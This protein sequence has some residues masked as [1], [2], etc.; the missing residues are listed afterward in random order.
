MARRGCGG[1]YNENCGPD[2]MLGKAVDRATLAGS[3]VVVAAGNGGPN[4][5]TISSPGTARTAITVGSSV[6]D[7][8]TIS[9]LYVNNLFMNSIGGQRSRLTNGNLIAEVKNVSGDGTPEDFLNSGNFV[10]KIALVRRGTL[11]LY[12][13]VRNSY[14]AGAVGVIIY[15]NVAGEF[16]P[17]FTNLTE[18]P[19]IGITQQD[20]NNLLNMLASGQVSANI[21]IVKNN[22]FAYTIKDYSSRGPIVTTNEILIKPDVVV[23]G[24]LV[25]SARYDS[26]LSGYECL[27]DK[28][29]VYDGTSMA[30]PHVSGLVALLKQKNP[31]WNSEEIKMAIRSKAIDSA[32]NSITVEGYGK[33]DA[34]RAIQFNG[35]PSIAS[36]KTSGKI[37]GIIDV[38]GSAKGRQFK[39]YTLYYGEGYDPSSWVVLKQGSVPVDNGILYSDFSTLSLVGKS[40]TLR[41]IV[42]NTNGEESEDRSF[43][44]VTRPQSKIVNK[45]EF[46]EIIS[47]M[48]RMRLEKLSNEAW[49]LDS[50]VVNQEI[51]ISRERAVKLDSYWNPVSVRAL[52]SG[53]YRTFVEFDVGFDKVNS[54]W[55]FTI[56]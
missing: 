13:K 7:F 21:S 36:I 37:G 20:G 8:G 26:F 31:D 3:V 48:L 47:G 5:G 24:Y 18:I 41:L 22:T 27:S 4:A 2:D 39:N 50:N 30:A 40:L 29:V 53:Q 11:W 43:V 12:E 52:T 45:E 28:Y 32:Q 34:L 35:I 17:T 15:N 42:T 14:N 19:A 54:T 25:C 44:D 9:K 33:A 10:G 16:Y 49:I 23:P 46:S 51:F 56:L 1:G 55:S 38:Y 6:N